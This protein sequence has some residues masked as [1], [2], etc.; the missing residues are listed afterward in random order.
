MRCGHDCNQRPRTITV[1]PPA[2]A[3]RHH[4]RQAHRRGTAGQRHVGDHHRHV[5][6]RDVHRAVG[7][8]AATLAPVRGAP[9]PALPAPRAADVGAHR[10]GVGRPRRRLRQ[11]RGSG[12]CAPRRCARQDHGRRHDGAVPAA[13]AAAA[14]PAP[15]AAV[16]AAAARH[17]RHRARLPR[18]AGRDA[19]AARRGRGLPA[20]GRV[21]APPADRRGARPIRQ[22][23]RTHAAPCPA[24]ARHDDR[25]RDRA[26]ARIAAAITSTPGA[27]A[28]STLADRTRRQPARDPRGAGAGQ[29]PHQAD[30]RAHRRRHVADRRRAGGG[31]RRSTD[32]RSVQ[33]HRRRRRCQP[34]SPDRPDAEQRPRQGGDHRH[35]A[36]RRHD[37]RADHHRARRRRAQRRGA[38]RRRA[39][40]ARIGDGGSRRHRP[41]HPRPAEGDRGLLRTRA[42]VESG[43]GRQAGHAVLDRLGGDRRRRRR[44]RGHAGRP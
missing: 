13:A 29:R 40:R 35:P 26:R 41:R 24:G 23:P 9:R 12:D 44:R 28:A 1:S 8:R 32:G 34:R 6:T 37:R 18:R 39:S 30:H 16:L 14:A 4:P 20:P 10:E 22:P 5:A 19:G 2:A 17:R 25:G 21:A 3:C 7:R 33:E 15:A 43:A 38:R 31:R 36:C 27:N 11:R 42:E